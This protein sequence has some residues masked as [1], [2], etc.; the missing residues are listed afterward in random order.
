MD[1]KMYWFCISEMKC[2][3][4]HSQYHCS[5]RIHLSIS[6]QVMVIPRAMAV[7]L[8]WHRKDGTGRGLW[9]VTCHKQMSRRQKKAFPFHDKDSEKGLKKETSYCLGSACAGDK[10]TTVSK[11]SFTPRA[12]AETCV[13]PDTLCV[14]KAY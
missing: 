6:V 1:S 9:S 4:N 10:E 8:I 5:S 12:V 3:F 14:G 7:L 11:L 13:V 2:C